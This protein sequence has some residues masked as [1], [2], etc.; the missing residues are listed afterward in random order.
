M[1]KRVKKVKFQE[2]VAGAIENGDELNFDP[3]TVALARRSQE[4]PGHYNGLFI[5][6][7]RKKE[8]QEVEHGI[9][10]KYP[11]EKEYKDRWEQ[12]FETIYLP[13]RDENGKQ[14]TDIVWNVE[15]RKATVD[16]VNKYPT[17]EL[18]MEDQ[19]EEIGPG[20]EST[21]GWGPKPMTEFY[22]KMLEEDWPEIPR[23]YAEVV[24]KGPVKEWD[25]AGPT[26]Y[27]GKVE[28]YD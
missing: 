27:Y 24:K 1:E 15:K 14:K 18:D 6:T 7:T 2:V 12:R 8:N 5:A 22:R 25:T 23:T 21:F 16:V 10:P 20:K 17:Y 28:D 13:E 26:R 3:R 4:R 11:R 19:I 9:F